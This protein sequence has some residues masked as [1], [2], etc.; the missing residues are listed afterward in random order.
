MA[1]MVQLET[2]LPRDNSLISDNRRFSHARRL[3]LATLWA[4]NSRP[5][6]WLSGRE[7]LVNK[8]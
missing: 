8:H 5:H 1:E 4:C 7:Q 2:H 6:T 3:L